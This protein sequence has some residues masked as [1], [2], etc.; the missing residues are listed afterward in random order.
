MKI[1]FINDFIRYMV[2]SKFYI[3][4][5]GESGIEW[6]SIQSSS[7]Q[8]LDTRKLWFENNK[9]ETVFAS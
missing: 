7:N 9:P 6:N 5:V 4:I 3:E 8:L 2:R 1:F